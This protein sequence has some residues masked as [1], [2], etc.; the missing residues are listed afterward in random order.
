MK[1]RK[2]HDTAKP[3]K[4]RLYDS[5]GPVDLSAVDSLRMFMTLN[6]QTTPKVNVALVPAPDQVADKGRCT[7]QPLAVDV[8]TAGTY[9]VE[10]QA[11]WPDNTQL[12]WPSDGYDRLAIVADLDNA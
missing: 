3:F 5:D 7:Y 4:L 11:H 2:R 6:Q 1:P 8:D 9:K 12:T 10:V